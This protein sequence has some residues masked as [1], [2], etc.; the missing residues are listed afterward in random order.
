MS[1]TMPIKHKKVMKVHIPRNTGRRLVKLRIHEKNT[2]IWVVTPYI[3]VETCRRFGG[4]YCVKL[5]AFWW[6]VLLP[7]SGDLVERTS[8]KFTH[9]YG[10]Y[11]FQIHAF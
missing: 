7:T 10:T 11:C 3:L 8:S 6:D 1:P 9:F 5:Q 4:T 2:A